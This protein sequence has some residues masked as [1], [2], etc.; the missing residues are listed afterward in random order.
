MK[1]SAPAPE[2]TGAPRRNLVTQDNRR[3]RNL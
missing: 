2:G 3:Y 1:C